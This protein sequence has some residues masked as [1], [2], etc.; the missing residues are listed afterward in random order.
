MGIGDDQ[1]G[2]PGRELP[3]PIE[4]IVTD[5]QDRPIQDAVVNFAPGA[6]AGTLSEIETRSD[7]QGRARVNWTLGNEPGPQEVQAT[8]SGSSGSPLDGAPVTFSAQAVRPPPARLVL[9]QPPPSIARNG[10]PFEQQPIVEVQDAEDLPIP[11]VEVVATIAS[12]GGALSGTVVLASDGTGRVTYSDL[13]IVGSGG[14]R[15]LG[16]S[17]TDPAV[18][19]ISG[20]IE[21][22]AGNAASMAAVPPVSYEEVV[23]SPVSPAPSVLVKD[24]DGNPVSGVAVTFAA[25]RDASVSPAI[26]ASDENGIAQVNSWTLG[27]TANVVYSLTARIEG[28][29]IPT[30]TFSA[31]AS[32]GAAGRLEIVTQPSTPAQSGVAFSQQPVIQIVDQN[33]NPT[34]QAGVSIEANV[35]AGPKG[36]LQNASATTDAAGRASFSGLALSGTV[37]NYTISFSSS[38]LRGVNSA[39]ITLQPGPPAQLALVV[40]PSSTARSRVALATQPVVQVQDASG[41]SIAQAGIQIAASITGGAATVGGTTVVATGADGRA[42]F[43][44]LSIIGSPGQKTLS[45]SGGSPPLE[46][47][48]AN[49]TLPNVAS[50]VLQTPPPSSAQVGSVISAAPS[51]TLLDPS[52]QPVADAPVTFA[53][54]AGQVLPGSTT[55]DI[56]GLVQVQTWTL[57][58][59][60]GEQQV[61]VTAVESG[62]SSQALVQA[63]AGPASQIVKI[64][65]EPQSAPPNSTLPEPLVVRVLDEFNNGAPDVTVD[66]RACDGTGSYSPVTDS[67]GFS[68]SQQPTGPEPGTFCTRASVSGTSLS[69][70]FAYTVTA[71]SS[72]PSQLRSSVRLRGDGLPP[73]A[74]VAPRAR[75]PFSR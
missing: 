54:S 3:Q 49:V 45:F 16:F 17:V 61:E 71:P 15:T 10:V 31:R 42:S 51:W 68:S 28:S 58:T 37:G 8:A 47:V 34:S 38:R 43:T 56:N 12:G 57:G 7:V 50:I 73:V 64:S 52:G 29:A 2:A 1:S 48:D 41:N 39:P 72:V 46:G 53:A 22:V 20:T 67:E 36:S 21:V 40:V 4:V 27:G 62:T 35:S 33:G 19:V 11:Q 60:A 24:S 59:T 18:E 55:S 66:W 65:G 70:D 26:V 32:A 63:T 69:V 6:G 74:P 25:D 5:D 30:I 23:N 75:R 13:A 9:L 44:D 14:P